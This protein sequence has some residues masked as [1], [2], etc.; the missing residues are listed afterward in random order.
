[1]VTKRAMASFNFGGFGKDCRVFGLALTLG[2]VTVVVLELSGVGMVEVKVSAQRTNRVPLFDKDTR[3]NVCGDKVTEVEDSFE[4]TIEKMWQVMPAV[5]CLLAETLMSIHDAVGT[6]F[7]N[8]SRD[9]CRHSI[10]MNRDS[11]EPIELG[12]LLGSGAFSFVFKVVK[13]D[14]ESAESIDL[15]SG[16]DSNEK[17][18]LMC[19]LRF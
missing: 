15:G 19:S 3:K 9:G 12:D 7:L 8:E 5:F 11:T 16:A 4:G 14:P 1:V 13:K 17:D 6:R 10:Y 2:L 18:K